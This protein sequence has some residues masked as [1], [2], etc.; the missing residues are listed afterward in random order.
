MVRE[1]S[2][3]KSFILSRDQVRQVDAVAIR[4]WGISGLVLMENAG[5]GIADELCAR[6]VSGPVT[7]ACSKGNNGGDGFVIARHLHL[8]GIGVQVLL[9]APPSE[10]VG[11]ALANFE[12]LRRT[13]IPVNFLPD[14]DLDGYFDATEWIV[15][16]LLGTGA[17]GAPR[18][19]LGKVIR[20]MNASQ[21]RRL[22]VDVP[23]G[24][25]CDSGIPSEN[26]VLAD[27]TG[28]FVALKPGLV[29]AQA[30]PYVGD[31]TVVSIGLP[32]E[33]VRLAVSDG[34]IC[35]GEE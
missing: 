13:S 4:D 25:D 8:R 12:F 21:A 18:A 34:R 10:L 1:T 6:R 11:D 2:P 3:M 24:L 31:V 19:P 7:V 20:A 30:R 9:C 27:V 22:A 35:E 23:S 16:A 26:T 32:V 33:L 29:T 14:I 28:T 17:R 5:R 15:D